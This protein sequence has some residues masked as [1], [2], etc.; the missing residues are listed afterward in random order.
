MA[1]PLCP[2]LVFYIGKRNVNDRRDIALQRALSI[3]ERKYFRW[4]EEADCM[5]AQGK[6]LVEKQE[7]K[8]QGK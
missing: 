3:M 6:G 5:V 8:W 1:L 4:R 7:M 2:F